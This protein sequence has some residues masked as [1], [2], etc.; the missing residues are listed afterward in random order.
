LFY[1]ARSF[2]QN[3]SGW[4]TSRVTSMR[5]AFREA[6]RFNNSLGKW[7][8][9][10]VTDMIY[11]FLGASSF[12]QDLGDWNVG[13]V[14]NMA[15]MF[16]YA[17]AFNG[18]IENWNVKSVT[19]MV[20]MFDAARSFKRN[21]TG[22]TLRPDQGVDVSE[23]FTRAPQWLS[24]YTNCGFDN[25]D[26]SVCAGTYATSRGFFDGPPGAWVTTPGIYNACTGGV[27]S[28][29]RS[30]AA[31]NVAV[32]RCFAAVPS[33]EKCC[34]TGAADCGAACSVD[35]PGWNTSL[36]TSISGLFYEARSFNQ[37]ISGW[38]TS[39]VTSMKDAFREASRFNNSLGEW[40]V[41]RVTDMMHM[42]L[43]ASSFNQDLAGWN[44]GQVT[45]MGYMFLNAQAF[46]GNIQNWN[47]KSVTSM[48][49][50]FDDAR[51]FKRN[52]TG[53]TLRPDRY[54][55]V[56]EMFTRA[57]QWLSTYTNCG[58]DNSDRSVCT[59]TYATS[60][61]LFNGPPG[62]WVRTP[63]PPSPP[64]LPSPPPS[65][66][67]PNSPPPSPPPPSPVRLI[68]NLPNERNAAYSTPFHLLVGMWVRGWNLPIAET[69]P[70]LTR[71]VSP[72]AQKMFIFKIDLETLNL[73]SIMSP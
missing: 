71:P 63:L 13:Q 38:D 47:V 35:M 67:P 40:D 22:W 61:G 64:P 48:R 33:G 10:R 17:Q 23:M 42:F 46:N 58:F 49:S 44:V 6:S 18:N 55:G 2:N 32:S 14:T 45:N 53:W 62:A 25:S 24:T 15:D 21:I 73:L 1:D 9:S 68:W 34:S 3:I 12:N 4:D 28:A 69:R 36:V 7:D 66:P 60:S 43:G 5:N 27:A 20:H 16:R 19:C 56:F 57:P 30:S 65:P 37:N 26:R 29:F 8:V 72:S 11:M 39:R 54:V 70:I 41:S 51:S 59:G 52:I 31:L 50:M